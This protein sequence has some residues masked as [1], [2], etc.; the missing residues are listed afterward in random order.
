MFN[1]LKRCRPDSRVII[2]L[3]FVINGIAI[4]QLQVREMLGEISVLSQMRLPLYEPMSGS[5]HSLLISE[6]SGHL[7]C[8]RR[9]RFPEPVS[10]SWV[11]ITF[12]N[13]GKQREQ[14]GRANCLGLV[15]KSCSLVR[16]TTIF[17]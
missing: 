6:Q 15:S 12:S 3:N 14:R 10:H 2:R 9:D 5:V 11:N 13:S 16:F 8:D 7:F 17:H 4:H 1:G